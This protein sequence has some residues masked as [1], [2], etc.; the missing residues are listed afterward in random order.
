M[1][2][3]EFVRKQ[4]NRRNSCGAYAFSHRTIVLRIVPSG[5]RRERVMA[6]QEA[7]EIENQRPIVERLEA[8]KRAGMISEYLLRWRGNATALMPKVTVWSTASIASDFVR[9]RVEKLLSG[10]VGA[11]QIVVLDD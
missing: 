6:M 9:R 4:T 8:A 11:K 10:F 5:Q 7:T 3:N 1:W 2:K